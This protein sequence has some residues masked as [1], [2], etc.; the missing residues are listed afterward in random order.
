MK[1]KNLFHRIIIFF[2]FCFF[3]FCCKKEHSNV[4]EEITVK[5]YFNFPNEELIDLFLDSIDHQMALIF[6]QNDIHK[7]YELA[8]ENA[9]FEIP[10]DTRVIKFLG[11]IISIILLITHA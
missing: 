1:S 4:A 11:S 8:I 3:L 10:I 6:G 7:N 5:S 2:I 9:T